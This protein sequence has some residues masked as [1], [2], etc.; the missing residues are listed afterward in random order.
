MRVGQVLAQRFRIDA[1]VGGGG[2]GQ[3][4]RA[5][6][7]STGEV[8]AAKILNDTS[9]ETV[10]RFE[11]EGRALARLSHP[12]IVR[13]IAYEVMPDG[14]PFL[15]MEWLE[16]EDLAQRL[17]RSHLTVPETITLATR[18]A[19]ALGVAHAQGIVHRDLKPGNVYLVGGR[20]ESPK[21]LDFGIAFFGGSARITAT[22]TM[23]GTPS[24][25]APEQARSGGIVDAS[26]DVFSLGCLLFECLSGRPPFQGDHFVAVLAKVIFEEAPRLFEL[27][28]VVPPW[29]EELVARMLSKEPTRRPRD[30]A[31]LARALEAEALE[32]EGL[33]EIPPRSLG[34]RERRF[35]GVVLLGPPASAP[36][37]TSTS[38][39]LAVSTPDTMRSVVTRF[40]AHLELLADGTAVVIL[41]HTSVP[42]DI[43]A[44]VARCALT[45]REFFPGVPIAVTTGWCE[46]GRGLPVGEAIE[47]ALW[48][49]HMEGSIPGPRV[50]IDETTAGLLDSRFDIVDLAPGGCELRGE[51]IA[52]E[53]FRPLLGKL[54]PCVGR[55]HELTLLEQSFATAEGEPAA[56]AVVVT[57]SAGVG[58]SRLVHEFIERRKRAAVPVEILWGRGDLQRAG[59][60]FGLLADVFWRAAEVKGGEPIEVRRERLA[61]FV[62][63][64]VPE[65]DLRRVT[66]FLGELSGI[67][68]SD[69]DSL[70]LRAA[71]QD[72]ELWGEQ[73][74]RAFR[75]FLRALSAERTALIVVED[76]HWGDRASVSAL[77]AALRELADEP[78]LLVATA[79]PEVEQV[80]PQLWVECGRQEI[81]LKHLS[82]KAS[83]RLARKVLGDAA[84]APLVERLVALSE[85][86]PFFLEELVRA[87]SEGTLGESLP[88]TIVA[89][90]QTRL[91]RLEPRARR[92]LRAASILGEVFWRGAVV[93][94]VGEGEPGSDPLA[95][96]VS[97]E[98]CLRHRESRF[99]GNEELS[100]RHALLREG[101]YA[102]LTDDDRQLGHRLAGE[103]L[104]RAGEADPLVL[105]GHFERGGL[106]DRAGT[107]YIRGAEQASARRN[108]QDAERYFARADELL[109]GLPVAARRARGLAR[110]RVGRH[111]DAVAELDAARVQAEA[112]GDGL[113]AVDLL[114]DEAMVLDWMGDVKRAEERVLAAK[115]CYVEGTSPLVDVRLLL[116]LGRSSDRADRKEEAARSLS[117]AAEKAARLG[118]E[119]YETRTIAF[120]L[121]G[122]ILPILGRLEE[123]AAALDDVIRGCEER[124]D[125]LH[126][127]AALS[128]RA[129]VRGYRGDRPGT[130][131]DLEKT[132]ELGRELGHPALELLGYYNLGEYLYLTDDLPAAEPYI[133]S[134]A[135][136]LGRPNIGAHPSIVRLLE[137][138]VALYRGDEAS[139][140]AILGSIRAEQAEARAQGTEILAPSEEVLCTMVEL[141][142][143]D[144][145]SERWDELE[146]RSARCSVGQERI[147]VLEARALTALRRG[148]RDD[149]ARQIGVALDIASRVANVM[150]PRLQR[151]L[152]AAKA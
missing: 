152:A 139:A 56:L 64:Y 71:R 119:G 3:V 141:A 70:P 113:A 80:F 147:E 115:A 101:A 46:L 7:L 106:F 34:K 116:G 118:E 13:Y 63:R 137:A 1:Q 39:T 33:D 65:R 32:G 29:L 135:A 96:L 146:E 36:P 15:V 97:G 59:S 127:G 129:L 149:A 11:R 94:M 105:A 19:D 20:I 54:T 114:L 111:A 150:T 102:L 88:G 24:Y 145:P 132:I 17:S 112:E 5:F 87:A 18:V 138:R 60:T 92:A 69:D 151:A 121:L 124:S 99:P 140:A 75:D 73:I 95:A 38:K 31:V 122:F 93:H 4:Y 83:A 136:A 2:M 8:V 130:V 110:F 52:A 35:L 142:A 16:G 117:A 53:A 30:G 6:D 143:T 100:F 89:M 131:S 123:A 109:S 43:A 81:R 55:E 103:W 68:F 98:I 104:E 134:A 26:A 61:A 148:R 22:G 62:A 37:I 133:R 82:A 67:P 84:D 78:I 51:R 86:H 90:V 79:R 85:G 12:G 42:T 144:A 74:R 23:M 10:M 58:K 44:Q 14:Q 76:V 50:A 41:D 126:L 57:G 48:L 9:T 108:Y 45:L 107:M 21:I 25:I 28:V 91:E 66:E 27:G 128:S 77:E 40:G 120:L 125:L 47:R 72:P 49:L